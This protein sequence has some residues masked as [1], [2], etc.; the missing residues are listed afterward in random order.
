VARLHRLLL[1][2]E[3]L[4][5]RFESVSLFLEVALGRLEVGDLV[6]DLRELVALRALL[7]EGAPRQVVP[8]PA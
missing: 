6:V 5:L 3:L 2:A 4:D 7:L 8:G 1:R